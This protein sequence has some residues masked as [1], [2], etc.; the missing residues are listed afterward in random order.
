MTLPT[1][2]GGGLRLPAGRI[3]G[4]ESGQGGRGEGAE[5]QGER[6]QARR[7]ESLLTSVLPQAQPK[8]GSLSLAAS[9]LIHKS[10]QILPTTPHNTGQE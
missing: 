8:A 9:L 6:K 1:P 4:D 3:Q 5:A 10:C 2:G 7:A